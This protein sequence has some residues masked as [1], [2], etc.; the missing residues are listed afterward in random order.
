[1]LLYS[2]VSADEVHPASSFVSVRD[3]GALGD[4]IAD[5]T[6]ALQRALDDG[7]RTNKIVYV[8]HGHY[9]ITHTLVIP[10]SARIVGEVWPVFLGTGVFF[11]DAKT[12]RPVIQVGQYAGQTGSVEI[13]ECIFSTRG[14]CRGAIVLQWNL[15]HADSSCMPGMWDTHIRLGGFKG[16]ALE[17]SRFDS[18]RPLNTIEGHACFLAW[19][20]PPQ[21]SGCFVNVWTWLADHTLDSSI[22]RNAG[23]QISILAARG[24]LIQSDPGPV[25][26][27]GGASEHFLLYQYQMLKARNVLIAHSQTESPYFLGEGQPLPQELVH[28]DATRW[29]DPRW[30]RD[31]QGVMD[32]YDARSW[33]M[34]VV[35]STSTVVIGAGLYSFFDAYSQKKLD[36]RQCQRAL[37]SIEGSGTQ[38]D[39]INVNTI[40]VQSMLD[41]DGH[42]LI[43]EREHRTGMPSTLGYFFHL[44]QK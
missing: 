17:D 29:G 22:G 42:E 26:L 4:G 10:P 19:H 43:N 15:R 39:L 1:M 25:C 34:R 7:A 41:V 32:S 14:P 27:W 2:A 16:S 13:S 24:I 3:Y 20:I 28:V 38:I 30:C 9:L 40:G 11:D 31:E 44:P 5:D 23:K 18:E 12:P 36:A 35:E 33:G 21:A 37:L 8:P 6:M